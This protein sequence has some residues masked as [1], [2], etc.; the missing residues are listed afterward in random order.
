MR[1]HPGFDLVAQVDDVVIVHD[2][3]SGKN[4]TKCELTRI[5]SIFAVMH[6]KRTITHPRVVHVVPALFDADIGIV[7]G[8]ERY[9]LEL[10]RAMASRTP[11]RLV[12]FGQ[13]AE[14]RH[15]DDLIVEIIASQRSVTGTTGQPFSF[16]L[17]DRFADADVIHC[18]QLLHVA[19]TLS[20]AYANRA[21]VPV[22]VTDLGGGPSTPT[23][24]PDT[25]GWFEGH[26]HISAFSMNAS[27]FAQ[28]TREVIGAGVDTAFFSPSA[29][30][31][32][33]R[34]ILFVGRILPHKGIDK[35]I[36][37]L[38]SDMT[39]TII[40]R[41]YDERYYSDLRSLAVGKKVTFLS[42][43]DDARLVEEYR[44]S[45]VVVLPSVHTTM[46]GDT[47]HTPELLGQ[48]LLEAMACAKP[49]VCTDVGGM[50][51]VVIDNET[52]FVVPPGDSI[53][54]QKTL[55]HIRDNPVRARQMGESGRARVT[56]CFA[57][58]AVVDRCLGAYAQAIR[59]R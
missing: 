1:N 14:I 53:A 55:E 49:T 52:G 35:L 34:K 33:E 18:H 28:G 43:L 32:D 42:D 54:L 38:P 22:F 23:S 4:S 26:L 39:L 47:I 51:E 21:G 57:W 30:S 19:T 59:A 50:P 45:A 6:S 3:R 25:S 36:D 5:I 40:G 9:A 15:L 7:G 29:D 48:T 2:A 24:I 11:T 20:A 58:P 37:V 17:F 56:K 16:D 44:N 41:I 8:A 10:A 31:F 27:A 13:V 12:T 46:Y